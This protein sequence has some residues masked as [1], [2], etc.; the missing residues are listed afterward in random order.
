MSDTE[1]NERIANR[2]SAPVVR[3]TAKRTKKKRTTRSSFKLRGSREKRAPVVKYE[4]IEDE[5]EE[6]LSDEEGEEEVKEEEVK[7]ELQLEEEEEKEEEAPESSVSDQ[8]AGSSAASPVRSL[9]NK[10]VT[11]PV[12]LSAAK[13][14]TPSSKFS[15]LM[16]RSRKQAQSYGM[17][18]SRKELT[19]TSVSPTAS[20]T[21][22]SSEDG[23]DQVATF[24]CCSLTLSLHDYLVL[25]LLI[26]SLI[27][28]LLLKSLFCAPFLTPVCGLIAYIPDS[29]VILYV[30]RSE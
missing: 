7:E 22:L 3:S 30:Y 16:K 19:N 18:F 26:T 29:K 17:Q 28:L 15:S 2:R 11:K 5:V 6:K 4:E 21:K 27:Y 24:T 12:S 14:R 9:R 20:S 25:S 10:K 23:D 8:E 1:N 13:K